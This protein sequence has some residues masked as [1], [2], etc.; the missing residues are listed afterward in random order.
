MA[1]GYGGP[2]KDFKVKVGTIKVNESDRE[3]DVASIGV[4]FLPPEWGGSERVPE[5]CRQEP[6]WLMLGPGM[7]KEQEHE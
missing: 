5:A 1:P 7:R 4:C 3:A 6:G 2:G